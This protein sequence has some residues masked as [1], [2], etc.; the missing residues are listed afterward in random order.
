M[1]DLTTPIGW[2][3]VALVIGASLALALTRK[4][5]YVIYTSPPIRTDTESAGCL[6]ALV[7]FLL[8]LVVI[9]AIYLTLS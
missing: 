7:S 1:N 3:V 9:G 8:A 5:T 6:R 4:P 2:F